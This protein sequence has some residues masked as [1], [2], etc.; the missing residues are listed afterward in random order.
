[1]RD[2]GGPEEAGAAATS[3]QV[4]SQVKDREKGRRRV[5]GSILD[6]YAQHFSKTT[7]ESVSQSSL[8]GDSSVSGE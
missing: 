8:S 6:C 3:M 4:W 1:M 2:A 5:D 7:R